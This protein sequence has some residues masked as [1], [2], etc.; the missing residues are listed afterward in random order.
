MIIKSCEHIACIESFKIRKILNNVESVTW[1]QTAVLLAAYRPTNTNTA[2]A[3][4]EWD[5]IHDRSRIQQWTIT[6][7][8]PR[9]RA[10]TPPGWGSWHGGPGVTRT[11]VS[12]ASMTQILFFPLCRS[13]AERRWGARWLGSE[14]VKWGSN[15]QNV[16]RHI[17]KNSRRSF[18]NSWFLFPSSN[19]RLNNRDLQ[20]ET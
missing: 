5:L 9:R 6:R 15:P 13:A 19:P 1:L 10:A 12:P 7:L 14:W 3:R 18:T 11:L 2:A 8:L 16:D 20:M 4:S 17:S